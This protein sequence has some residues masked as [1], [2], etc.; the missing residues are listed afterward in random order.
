LPERGLKRG[1]DVLGAIADVVPQAALGDG[2]AVVLREQG[3]L[4][5]APGL[6]QRLGVL[7]EIDVADPLEEHQREDVSLEIGLVD[8]AA[9]QVSRRGEVLL[10]LRQRQRIAPAVGAQC[11]RCRAC[12]ILGHPSP[13]YCSTTR[14]WR[15]RLSSRPRGQRPLTRASLRQHAVGG[16]DRHASASGDAAQRLASI[17]PHPNL[18]LRLVA[19]GAGPAVAASVFPRC[20][21]ASPDAGALKL[22]T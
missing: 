1:A 18:A 7:L 5:V 16:S 20:A 22:S 10:E 8:A 19:S 12:L 4:V 3:E 11:P 6:V 9:Q 17:S 15:Y 13:S 21:D 14:Q 2:E